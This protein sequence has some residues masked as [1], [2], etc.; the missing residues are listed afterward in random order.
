MVIDAEAVIQG[1]NGITDFQAL[2][3]R[4]SKCESVCLCLRL[5][6]RCLGATGVLSWKVYS[7]D[8]DRALSAS[9]DGLRDIRA[10]ETALS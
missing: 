7:G 5:V 3:G 9:S 6:V 2:H 1:A 4:T 10:G 8:P